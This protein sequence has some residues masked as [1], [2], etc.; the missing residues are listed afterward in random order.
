MSHNRLNKGR[1]IVRYSNPAGRG[2]RRR[3]EERQRVEMA[4]KETSLEKEASAE[5]G[6]EWIEA[7]LRLLQHEVEKETAPERLLEL[8]MRLE[9]LVA[10]RC[11]RR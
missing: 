9:Q 7:E 2:F 4:G 11:R 8:A 3:D 6:D 10:L 1:D 5:I